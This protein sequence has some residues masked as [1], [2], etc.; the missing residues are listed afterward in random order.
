VFQVK[1]IPGFDHA[2]IA[3]QTVVEKRL[4]REQNKRIDEISPEEFLAYCSNWK[5]QRISDISAQLR[6]LYVSLDWDDYIF[7]TMDE[8]V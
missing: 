3:T 1:W 6:Q 4:L 5:D 7:Y 8:V 2:G